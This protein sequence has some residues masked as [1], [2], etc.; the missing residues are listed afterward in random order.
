MVI[1]HSKNCNKIYYICKMKKLN[2]EE[3]VNKANKIHNNK[4]EYLDKEY[5][6]NI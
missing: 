5:K 6:N 2:F 1:T 3:F 4:Y